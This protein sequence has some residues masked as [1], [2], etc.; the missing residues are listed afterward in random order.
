MER[1]T[2]DIWSIVLDF[3]EVD[4]ELMVGMDANVTLPRSLEGKTGA[5]V[6]STRT[7]HRGIL[8]KLVEWMGAHNLRA[9]N[10]YG[11]AGETTTD[12]QLWTRRLWEKKGVRKRY[13]E[14]QDNV[15]RRKGKEGRQTEEG[16]GTWK[17]AKRS[18][19]EDEEGQE[20]TGKGEEQRVEK[21]RKVNQ[22]A[23]IDYLMTTTEEGHAR[24]VPG[25]THPVIVGSDHRPV[26]GEV[27]CTGEDMVKGGWKNIARGWEAINEEE[28]EKYRE[29]VTDRLVKEGNIHNTHKIIYE[30]ATRIKYSTMGG[31]RNEEEK[32]RKEGNGIAE[33][34]RELRRAGRKTTEKRDI[35]RRL[36]KAKKREARKKQEVFL[37][38][39]VDGRKA[40]TK[41]P[42]VMTING[43]RTA[44]N[45][46]WVQRGGGV[47]KGEIWGR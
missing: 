17:K 27:K 36:D 39:A 4:F 13:E 18:R 31:R 24:A 19:E 29:R 35:K 9:L 46:I 47:G 11:Q 37:R 21:N 41:D 42:I 20:G 2:Q 38:M 40:K 23:Q 7:T 22:E 6:I 26:G 33:L 1:A 14:K 30:E 43:E 15:K 34:K 45:D 5:N 8:N 44:D 25:L 32:K 12:E 28:K 16:T 10:T 3:P